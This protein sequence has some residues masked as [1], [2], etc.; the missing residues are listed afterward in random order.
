MEIPDFILGFMVFYILI[1]TMLVIGAISQYSLKKIEPQNESIKK[2]IKKFE[3]L[4]LSIIVGFF[5]GAIVII[6]YNWTNCSFFDCRQLDA[7][8]YYNPWF[9][10]AIAVVI[11]LLIVMISCIIGRWSFLHKKT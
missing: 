2:I 11:I 5:T 8:N 3:D 1:V 6:Y 10:P 4:I 7:P 9:F